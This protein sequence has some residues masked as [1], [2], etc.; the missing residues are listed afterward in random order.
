MRRALTCPK[1]RGRSFW[2]VGEVLADGRFEAFICRGCGLTAWYARG[3][4]DDEP[5]QPVGLRCGECEAV[6]AFRIEPF[7]AREADGNARVL[8]VFQKGFPKYWGEGRFG[9]DICGDC[10]LTRWRAL[11]M[12]AVEHSTY[13]GF[14]EAR[15]LPPCGACRTRRMRVERGPIEPTRDG[16]HFELVLCRQCGDTEW[17][18]RG[19]RDLK[20]SREW[21][22]SLVEAP[23]LPLQ[24]GPYR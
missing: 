5:L 22:I 9:L 10:G 4:H 13:Y 23:S 21:R 2:L 24:L 6:R 7:V 19:L 3:L 17:Y 20:P 16:G 15:N 12:R 1:C 11:G 14:T 18:A 8:R